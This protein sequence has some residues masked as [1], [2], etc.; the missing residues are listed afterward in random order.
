MSATSSLVL[1]YQK[2]LPESVNDR[3]LVMNWIDSVKNFFSIIFSKSFSID[4]KKKNLILYVILVIL[5]LFLCVDIFS[6]IEMKIENDQNRM[7]NIADSCRELGVTPLSSRAE[8]SKQYRVLSKKWHPD[9]NPGCE[10]CKEKYLV[11]SRS[12]DYLQEHL[13]KE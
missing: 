1:N 11:I 5:G 10:S 12:Y 4:K 8:I 13:F 9:K 2:S 3:N 7:L 6:I